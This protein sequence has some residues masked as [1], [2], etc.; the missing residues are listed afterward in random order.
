M[1]NSCVAPAP[2]EQ[3]GCKATL[4]TA[5][6]AG[7]CF[8]GMEEILRKIPGVIETEVGAEVVGLGLVDKLRC[9]LI[10]MHMLVTRTN[11]GEPVVTTNGN[12]IDGLRLGDVEARVVRIVQGFIAKSGS[13]LEKSPGAVRIM[14]VARWPEKLEGLIDAG[15][16]DPVPV[17]WLFRCH[18]SSDCKI[19][20]IQLTGSMSM[21]ESIRNDLATAAH[22][23][24]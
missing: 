21:A 11:G 13:T 12:R 5:I 2:G 19:V 6:L 1:P 23:T 10:R 18:S 3:P 7:G 17:A 22:C 20:D 24:G 8:C 16:G 9:D 4:D 14:A 15:Q